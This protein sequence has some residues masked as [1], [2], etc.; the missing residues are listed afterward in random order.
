MAKAV[1]AT[2]ASYTGGSTECFP[3][4]STVAED[5]GVSKRSVIR[6]L[7]ELEKNEVL[8]KE[9]VG[10]NNRYHLEILG[11][12]KKISGDTSAP[13]GDKSA[14]IG[15]THVTSHKKSNN[16][17]NNKEEQLY[18][19]VS[20]PAQPDVVPDAEVKGEPETFETG[21]Q[22]KDFT[23]GHTGEKNG[24][25]KKKD[26]VAAAKAKWKEERHQVMAHLNKVRGTSLKPDS[27]SPVKYINARLNEGYTV[28]NLLYVIDVKAKQWMGTDMERHLVPQTLFSPSKFDG[29]LNEKMETKPKKRLVM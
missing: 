17:S 14:Q 25:K 26:K 21:H 9:K 3:K 6:A 16:K 18:C 5:L 22:E 4:I 1:Y 7:Q 24:G 23:D 20:P 11:P 13:I 29:Y 15:D 2:L 19:Q 27:Q 8:T 10:K 12:T 28:E